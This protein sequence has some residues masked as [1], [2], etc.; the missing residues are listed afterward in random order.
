MPPASVA[1]AHRERPGLIGL[2]RLLARITL[3]PALTL[4]LALG[5][6]PACRQTDPPRSAVAPGKTPA[7][8]AAQ[9]GKTAG[10][11]VTVKKVI[12]GDTLLVSGLPTGTELVRLIGVNAPETGAGRTTR[13]CFGAEAQSWLFQQAPRGSTLTLVPDVGERD[14]FGRLLFYAYRPDGMFL[15]A[16]LVASGYG[17]TMT[18]PPNVSHAEELRAL[19]RR[20]R[21]E[22]RGLWQACR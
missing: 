15:N 22:K 14:R 13:Q 1:Q 10:L 8:P 3:R 4:A 2:R 7:P 20:A 5:L 11:Q 19:E 18:I 12:D 21:R 16:A 17:Q 6:Y 9:P